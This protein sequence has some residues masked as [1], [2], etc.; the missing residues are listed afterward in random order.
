MSTWFIKGYDSDDEDHNYIR[1]VCPQCG[2]ESLVVSVPSVVSVRVSVD[3]DGDPILNDA[4]TD[5]IVEWETEDDVEIA[6]GACDNCS[7]EYSKERWL[8]G[9][10]GSCEGP[11]SA[12]EGV[13]HCTSC[14]NVSDACECSRCESCNEFSDDCECSVCEHCEEVACVCDTCSHCNEKE[15]DC[16]CSFCSVCNEVDD[17]CQCA[18]CYDTNVVVV[19]CECQKCTKRAQPEAPPVEK[20]EAAKPAKKSPSDTEADGSSKK[21]QWMLPEE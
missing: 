4:G 12:C 1:C 6:S 13:E 14:Y 10:C 18:R 19:V 16:G 7:E 9:Y 17:E 8:S 3:E 11:A 5:D 21:F 2:Y 20:Y 15:A